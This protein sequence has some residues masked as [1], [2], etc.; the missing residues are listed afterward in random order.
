M[1]RSSPKK[2]KSKTK[3]V[4]PPDS[5]P[6]GTHNESGKEDG[7]AKQDPP[8]K[9][10]SGDD[11]EVRDLWDCAG[12]RHSKSQHYLLFRRKGGHHCRLRC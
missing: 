4:D 9:E 12:E 6:D 5:N 7:D 1:S 2:Q 10:G 3:V 11:T 8:P